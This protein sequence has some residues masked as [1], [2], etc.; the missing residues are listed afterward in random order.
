MALFYNNTAK[1]LK[2]PGCFF[3]S[4][5]TRSVNYVIPTA[6]ITPIHHHLLNIFQAM[7]HRNPIIPFNDN[8]VLHIGF[9]GYIGT[10]CY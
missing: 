6:N 2:A 7:I 5:V 10:I 3:L 8:A 4:Q 9:Y 1:M